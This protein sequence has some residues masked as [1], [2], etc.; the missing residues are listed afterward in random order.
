MNNVLPETYSSETLCGQ[1]LILEVFGEPNS[2][3]KMTLGNR[4]FYAV[5][6]FPSNSKNQELVNWFFDYYK[7]YAW[8]LNWEELKKGWV[9]YQK[10]RKQ[11]HD[12]VSSAFW[13]YFD[14]K[15]IKVISR[16]KG[17]F[18]WI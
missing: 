1:R 9:C 15:S 2:V 13:N 4:F 18:E 7:N 3:T 5:K 12:S 16:A 6:C 10:A 11:R 17:R 8:L 14:G